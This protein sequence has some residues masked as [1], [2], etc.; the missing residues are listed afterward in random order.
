M[1]G[2]MAA[3]YGNMSFPLLDIVC[4]ATEVLIPNI[5]LKDTRSTTTIKLK[6]MFEHFGMPTAKLENIQKS[7]SSRDGDQE[8]TQ[9]CRSCAKEREVWARQDATCT[10]WKSYQ[11]G[12]KS[13]LSIGE[14]KYPGRVFVIDATVIET[15]HDSTY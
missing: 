3:N 6:T 12:S 2:G 5:L 9:S 14:K 13:T 10:I 4:A 8:S 1:F 11:N 7:T 15:A